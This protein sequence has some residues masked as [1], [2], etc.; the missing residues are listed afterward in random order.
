[1]ESSGNP[2]LPK[3][4]DSK[5]PFFTQPVSSINKSVVQGEIQTFS[6]LGDHINLNAKV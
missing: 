3:G 2:F 5:N 4:I 6:R 1:M